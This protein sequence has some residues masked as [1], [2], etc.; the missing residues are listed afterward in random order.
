MPLVVTRVDVPQMSKPQVQLIESQLV[1]DLLPPAP[2]PDLVV[3]EPATP[4]LPTPLPRPAGMDDAAGQN[5][6]LSEKQRG[7]EAR[8]RARKPGVNPLR[9]PGSQAKQKS[10]RPRAAQ[11][12][13][14]EFP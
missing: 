3:D 12:L 7:I 11:L 10:G 4:N 6:R 13:L 9:E 1:V 2:G 14:D 8:E 5:S